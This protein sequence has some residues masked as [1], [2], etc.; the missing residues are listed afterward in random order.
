M[1][2]EAEW[3]NRPG[4]PSVRNPT[5][6]DYGN[7]V[8]NIKDLLC[9]F[10]GTDN[11]FWKWKQQVELLRNSYSLEDSATR[12]LISS[13]LK[14]KAL[15][16]F[17]SR[18]EHVVISVSELWE[19]MRQ[20]FDHRPSK[21]SLRREFERRVWQAGESFNE[22]YHSKVI[23]ANRVPI[24]H[25]ELVD[26]ITDGIPDPRL[27]DQARIQ[28]FTE[29][30]GLVEAFEKIM[31]RSNPK[32]ERKNTWKE[33][34][35]PKEEVKPENT[36]TNTAWRGPSRCFN[37]KGKGHR[38]ADCKKPR[39]APENSTSDRSSNSDETSSKASTETNL[40]QPAIGTEPY[41]VSVRYT[42]PD[43]KGKTHPYSVTAIV[44]TRSPVSLIKSK[45]APMN[46]CTPIAK[47]GCKYYDVNE[48]QIETLGI[49]E[50]IVKIADI[51]VCVKFLVVPETTMSAAALLGRDFTANKIRQ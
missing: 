3:T 46:C 30:S 26:Y 4:V 50:R 19:K 40:I 34:Q 15:D 23:L 12:V 10:N 47:G 25:S 14:G 20:M 29:A 6:S 32:N 24:D 48:S 31:L 35:K 22:Y 45:Y 51:S 9:D 41:T 36:E 39:T 7:N 8:R 43:D 33:Q 21:L 37:C 16:W 1:R 49:F 5:I 42:I 38:A 28:H 17:H 13:K 2:R 27:R 18:L 44:D 11:E